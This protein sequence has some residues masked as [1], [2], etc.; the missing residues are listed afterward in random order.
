MTTEKGRGPPLQ[1]VGIRR[2][3]PF[4]A[5]IQAILREASIHSKRMI[6]IR[7]LIVKSLFSLSN[8]SLTIVNR[9]TSIR[10]LS[11]FLGEILC[12]P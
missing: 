8:H 7:M 6:S 5:L 9:D 11:V 12:I 1:M 4:V 2:K 3:G 10:V